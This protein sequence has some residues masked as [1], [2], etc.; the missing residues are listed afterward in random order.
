MPV[1]WLEHPAWHNGVFSDWL[2]A[3]LPAVPSLERYAASTPDRLPPPAAI[4]SALEVH[5]LADR[6]AD[7]N[8]YA[9]V[10]TDVSAIPL[11]DFLMATEYLPAG[12]RALVGH[13]H[14]PENA[15]TSTGAPT[16]P[17]HPRTYLLMFYR[18]DAMAALHEAGAVQDTAPPEDWDELQALLQAHAGAVSGGGGSR[19][20]G[21]GGGG[22]G[23][24]SGSGDGGGSGSSNG[25]TAADW[26]MPRYGLC[27]T[28]DSA[29]GRHGDVF[30]A[31]AASIVQSGGTQQGY[32]FDLI[33]TPP[34]DAVPLVNSTGWRAA[35]DILTK[36]LQYNAPE[37]PGTC[38]GVSPAFL[39]GD[40][41]LTLEYDAA[42]PYM[43]SAALRQPGRLGVAP[44]PGSRL[45][46]SREP[47]GGWPLVPCTRQ[48]CSHSVNHDL[49]YLRR[50]GSPA[51]AAAETA[52][53]QRGHQLAVGGAV[54][55]AF[56]ALEAAAVAALGQ[57]AESRARLINR[58]P[59][60]AAYG[61]HAVFSYTS[62]VFTKGP[63]I[64]EGA[65]ADTVALQLTARSCVSGY[66]AAR[67]AYTDGLR[68]PLGYEVRTDGDAQNCSGYA[69]TPWWTVLEGGGAAAAPDLRPLAAA[70]GLEDAAAVDAYL[71]AL[72]HAVHHPN[73][74]PDIQSPVEVNWFKYALSHAALELA[75]APGG[76]ANASAASRDPAAAREAALALL[77]RFFGYVNTAFDPVTVREKYAASISA[78]PWRPPVTH[79]GSAKKALSGGALAGV[80]VAA[81]VV[82]LVAVLAAAVLALQRRR[83]QRHRDLLGRVIAPRVGPDT[84]LLVTDIQNS[85]TMWEQVPVAAMDAAV[86]T[87]HATIRQLLAEH[88]GYESATEGDSFLI[89][90]VD[91]AR[92]LAF[93]VA[94]QLALLGQDWPD[95][96]LSHP[97][98]EL[99]L[100]H[101][102]DEHLAESAIHA[103]GLLSAAR[104]PSERN[105]R[106]GSVAVM[107]G[108]AAAT[109]NNRRPTSAGERRMSGLQTLG[110]SGLGPPTPCIETP[111][112][113]PGP[114][115]AG[116]AQQV[117]GPEPTTGPGQG[118]AL[119]GA[120][121][122]VLSAP[123]VGAWQLAAALAPLTS[124]PSN[125]SNP[126]NPKSPFSLR[127]LGLAA[128]VM[129]S[130]GAAVLSGALPR[131]IEPGPGSPRPAAE[132]SASRLFLPALRARTDGESRP[133]RLPEPGATDEMAP[134]SSNFS[135][136]APSVRGLAGAWS[137]PSVCWLDALAASFTLM[138]TDLAEGE[139]GAIS[140]N[141]AAVRLRDGRSAVVAYRGLRVR[142]GLHSGLNDVGQMSYNKVGGSFHY[143][144]AFA[145]T[146]KHTSD[147]APGGLISLSGSAFKRLRISLK[148]SGGPA[149]RAAAAA[150]VVYAGHH[151][152]KS[153]EAGFLTKPHIASGSLSGA[154]ETVDAGQDGPDP[155]P[156]PDPEVAVMAGPGP[157]GE[158]W[159]QSSPGALSPVRAA[160][161]GNGVRA[162]SGGGRAPGRRLFHADF[163]LG[164]RSYREVQSAVLPAT[165][166]LAVAVSV[167]EAANAAGGVIE[168]R[169]VTLDVF[170]GALRDSLARSAP[171]RP[172]SRAG[173]TRTTRDGGLPFIAS[174]PHTS[175]ADAA[176]SRSVPQLSN[177]NRY[178][179]AFQF[180]AE[181]AGRAK[182]LFLAVPPGLLCRLVLSP[183]LRTVHQAQLGA[184][185]APISRIT[186][187]FMKVV[188]AS[189][190]LGDLP[191]P[192]ARALDLFQRLT[193]GLLGAA[194]G[195]LVEGGDGLVLAAFGRPSAAVLWALQC[196]E[197]LKSQD[198]EEELLGHELCSEE[199]SAAAPGRAL[200]APPRQ[201]SALHPPPPSALSPAVPG[202]APSMHRGLRVKV[203]LDS[204]HVSHSLEEASGRLSYRGRVMN[205]A[206]RIA[207]IAAAG[208]VLCSAGTWEAC[209]GG[210]ADTGLGLGLGGGLSDGVGAVRL[211]PMGLKGITHPVEV[212]QC[213]LLG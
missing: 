28:A 96:L 8:S 97:D 156:D 148:G 197:Q 99:V 166:P 66:R 139:L 30:A 173:S 104:H 127:T 120:N 57:P 1:P 160:S 190:L 169:S 90:F 34:P 174:G 198:W 182:S 21:G 106:R 194:G 175:I 125:P 81:A 100:V 135:G 112:A 75:P 3:A 23:G 111:L 98:G 83:R 119:S 144:G 193:G 45:V 137:G 142:M 92:A 72:W 202:G 77:T 26:V 151:V 95:E 199:V 9:L 161:G 10:M 39:S 162:A 94:A 146:A 62:S 11:Y 86:K 68:R 91:P 54:L 27:V 196:I 206:A 212:V 187:A 141:N 44:L 87:H 82:A 4:A 158:A 188:G 84:T 6:P 208:Q 56:A 71:Q 180:N 209:E 153:T 124:M 121:Q 150:T 85:T 88:D 51:A 189:T 33:E 103:R 105:K 79:A 118:Q 48:L 168:P 131:G 19:G 101:A 159:E 210:G 59:Y 31:I 171:I 76:A 108:L 133:D 20:A 70:A 157:V 167:N 42:L 58:A 115:G 186:V 64:N 55:E 129:G 145:A 65:L 109:A 138:E 22:S 143:G 177:Y 32:A 195:F 49:L 178:S 69:A 67:Q 185:A 114:S 7:D 181:L 24:G 136:W 184:L 204:G 154:Q 25:S 183:P 46:M 13:N 93:A 18:P 12:A 60:S 134:E 203:G 37:P 40:C 102:L 16:G 63:G 172:R 155:D 47:G 116:Y 147:V 205:R 107:N 179:C 132:P 117:F 80:V 192:A 170:G 5:D 152:L 53:R 52:V 123:E 207:G 191:G 14:V 35:A 89:A 50:W 73:S 74:A 164:G 61:I 165:A 110:L 2:Q 38:R 176:P 41:L 140:R 211:G 29:C 36:L 128:L 126:S 78:P 130:P 17:I 200:A 201:A 149:T 213:V 163:R 43:S 113:S 15:C 122:P